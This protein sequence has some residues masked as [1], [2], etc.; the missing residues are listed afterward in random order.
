[1]ELPTETVNIFNSVINDM[2]TLQS[3]YDTSIQLLNARLR[4]IIME[5]QYYLTQIELLK[6]NLKT[7]EITLDTIRSENIKLL[8]LKTINEDLQNELNNKNSL[9][10]KLEKNIKDMEDDR[11]QFTKVSHVIAMEK[12]NARLKSE[13]ETFKNKIIPIQ[14]ATISETTSHNLELTNQE[15]E[16][17]NQDEVYEKKI[18]G[19]IYFVS[20]SDN[21]TVFEKNNDGTIGNEVGYL[22]KQGDKFK[23]VWT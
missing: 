16:Y 14:E 11:K 7:T 8:E 22:E 18:K 17:T 12:E 10:T 13:L 21:M 15:E 20:K 5:N 2:Q 6:E 1:M 3:R 9:I 23:M 4:K 19:K